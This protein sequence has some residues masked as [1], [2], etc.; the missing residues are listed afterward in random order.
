MII[1]K[2]FGKRGLFPKIEIECI[3]TS[4]IF[5]KHKLNVTTISEIVPKTKI[6]CN[7]TSEI[8]PKNRMYIQMDIHISSSQFISN[9]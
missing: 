2:L 8:V 7:Y 6:E 1:Y 5:P 3:C 9:I 4:E